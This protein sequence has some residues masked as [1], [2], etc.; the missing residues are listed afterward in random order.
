MSTD[1]TNRQP[2]GIPVGGQF[3]ATTHSDPEVRLQVSAEH[4]SA[5]AEMGA[6]SRAGISHTSATYVATLMKNSPAAVWDENAATLAAANGCTV[7]DI[8]SIDAVFNRGERPLEVTGSGDDLPDLLTAGGLTG[9]LTPYTGSHP[10]IPDKAWT[11]TSGTGR[12]LILSRT[13]DGGFTVWNDDPDE[14]YSFSV[15]TMPGD[16][17]PESSV[18]S[19]QDVLWNRAVTDANYNMTGGLQSGD[20]YELREVTLDK[21]SEGNTFGEV[22]ASN[23][24]G[25]WTT[26]HHDFATGATTV[27]RDNERLEGAAADWEMAAVFEGL[28]SEPSDGDFNVH[29]KNVFAGLL[30]EAAKDPDAPRWA[31]RHADKDDRS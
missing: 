5:L 15:E 21:D 22:L 24:D 12:E 27:D 28:H 8:R 19:V 20:F 2:K 31:A 26:L 30:A 18:E 14:D 3:A 10:D 17:T 29:A 16:V 11:Y 6:A 23:E 7:D 9:H 4:R 13:E 1:T 25:M